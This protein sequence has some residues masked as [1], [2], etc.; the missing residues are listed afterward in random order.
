MRCYI[1]WVYL[2]SQSAYKLEVQILRSCIYIYGEESRHNTLISKHYVIVMCITFVKV[3]K[4]TH[5]DLDE[6]RRHNVFITVHI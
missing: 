4:D 2:I 5:Y 6:A 3:V 1:Q